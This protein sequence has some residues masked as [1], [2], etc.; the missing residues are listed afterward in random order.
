MMIMTRERSARS[1]QRIS[2]VQVSEKILV[3]IDC[4]VVAVAV[5]VTSAVSP[6]VSS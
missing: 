5:L 2:D 1:Q 4:C 6:A 3:K